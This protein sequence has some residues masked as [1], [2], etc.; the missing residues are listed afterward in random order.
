M[1]H[2]QES[3]SEMR[4]ALSQDPLSPII[5]ANLAWCF[6][7]AHDYNSAIQQARE[8]LD[9]HPD[10]AVAHEY[11]GQAYA[12]EMKTDEALAEFQQ[13]SLTE[14]SRLSLMAYAYGRSGKKTQGHQVVQQL[15]K[16][17]KNIPAYYFAI[18]YAGLGEEDAALGSLDKSYEDRDGHLVNLKVHPA[19]DR[20]HVSHRAILC[21]LSEESSKPWRLRLR[22]EGLQRGAAADRRLQGAGGRNLL[23]A[24][25]RTA[26]PELVFSALSRLTFTVVV[27]PP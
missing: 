15:R 4:L 24:T 12:E 17:E 6:Y 26:T 13:A 22:S 27:K 11:L 18:A 19:F 5:S 7:L 20:L 1:G 16:D 21:G 8:T 14:P 23:L 9:L 10:F 2:R 25:T 3:L